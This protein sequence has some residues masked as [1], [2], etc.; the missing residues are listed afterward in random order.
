MSDLWEEKFSKKQDRKF[1]KHKETGETSWTPP[2]PAAINAKEITKPV[3]S[4]AVEWD[5]DEKYSEKHKKKFWKHKTTGETT[6][7]EPHK[8]TPSATASSDKKANTETVAA[9]IEWDW[10]EKYSEKHKKKFWKHKTT[11]ETTWKEPHK[12]TPSAAASSDK[13]ANA[14]TAPVVAVVEWDWDEKYSEKHKKKFWKHK[15]TGETTWK[16]P[17]KPTPSAAAS[18]DKKANAETAPVVA[19]VE[20][21]W[22]EKYSEKHKKK[23]WKHKTTGETTWKEPLKP[24]VVTAPEPV[25]SAESSP[26]DTVVA[27]AAA[28]VEYEEIDDPCWKKHHSKE[29]KKDYWKNT[30]TGKS[31]WTEPPKIK[32][33]VVKDK[34]VIATATPPSEAGDVTSAD[35]KLEKVDSPTV[36]KPVEEEKH[37]KQK[38]ESKAL[39]LHPCGL[40]YQQRKH[41]LQGWSKL[42]AKVFTHCEESVLM[43]Y[44]K[45][46]DCIFDDI[47]SVEKNLVSEKLSLEKDAEE[48]K[49]EEG[50]RESEMSDLKSSAISDSS[51]LFTALFLS[52]FEAISS[53]VEVSE[54][55]FLDCSFV[56]CLLKSFN[57]ILGVW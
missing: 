34:D 52:D 53:N 45:S 2:P 27:A 29:K 51:K 35:N 15:T 43:L 14:E 8:P 12:P 4:A 44:E 42:T 54:G 26:T 36:T 24:K 47:T 39:S 25:T 19:V 10:D 50:K 31:T 46:E 55:V 18:S 17:L 13:K 40:L 22:D 57:V 32:R 16:E 28:A 3:A 41:H 37:E 1:W 20:W 30:T 5:W 38:S 6:W 49:Q 21:D 11:G 23:F 56:L 33:V 48:D 9:V 7:K